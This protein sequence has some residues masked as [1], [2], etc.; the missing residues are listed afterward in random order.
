VAQE[1]LRIRLDAVD[2][3]KK[4]FNSLKGNTDS[5]K[6]SLLNLKNVLIGLGAGVAF[7][8]IVNAGKQ[9]EGLGL[10][11]KFL[12]GSASEGAKAFDVL[13]KFASKVPFSLEEISAASG[14]L[15]VVSKDADE[16]SKILEITGNVAAVTGL[17]FQT[18]ASQIQ[19]AFSGGI[20][21]ADVF[22]EKGVRNLLGFSAG[23]TVSAEDTA[24]KFEEVFGKGGR[25]GNATSELASSFEGVLSMLGDKVFAFRKKIAQS[26]FFEA[27]KTQFRLLDQFIEDNSVMFDEFATL[28]GE[29][30]AD[31]VRGLGRGVVF[32][33]ENFDKFLVAIETF[34]AYKL[35]TIVTNLGE[36]FIILAGKITTATTAMQGFNTATAGLRKLGGIFAFFLSFGTELE[37]FRQKMNKLGEEGKKLKETLDDLGETTFEWTADLTVGVEEAYEILAEFEHELS[38]KIPSALEKVAMSF[39]DLVATELLAMQQSINNIHV[40][41]AQGIL[42]GIKQ[43]SN[44]LAEAIILGK[45]LGNAFKQFVVKGI[46]SALGALINYVLQKLFLYAL[47]KLFPNLLK[48]QNLLEYEKLD[49]LRK[50]TRE[51]QKQLA[52]RAIMSFFGGGFAEGGF[53]KGGRAEGGRVNGYRANGGQTSGTNTYIVGERG[54]ELFIPSTDGQIVSNENLKTM[55]GANITFNINA[56]DVKGVKELL[57]DNRAT[58]TN[59][60]NS[61]LNQKGKPALV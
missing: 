40:T 49:I 59:I 42:D 56:T 17:D 33:Y 29:T 38:A 51:L 23:A 19:R 55:G 52:L 16:L 22:R 48:G 2:N 31:A 11:F 9:I 10:R 7:R 41:I 47:E 46:V 60:I 50:Q 37:K 5:A 61:A 36:S 27:F 45:D 13:A 26:D 43:F 25:F 6:T 53:M 8:S 24:K 58:I 30:L 15:A 4:A 3:T 21:A 39:A 20:A 44:I 28:I 1:R 54:R 32:V 57:I 14:N 12:F 18:T 35:I 34:I